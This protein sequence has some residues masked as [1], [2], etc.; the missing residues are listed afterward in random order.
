MQTIRK[1]LYERRSSHAVIDATAQGFLFPAAKAASI[2]AMNFLHI[3]LHPSVLI[4]D[5]HIFIT[6]SYINLVLNVLLH[7]SFYGKYLD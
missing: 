3:I 1:Q 7:P 5:F 2:T 4:Y 6:S